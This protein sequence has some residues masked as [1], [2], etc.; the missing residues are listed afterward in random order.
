MVATRPVVAPSDPTAVGA[1]PALSLE[2]VIER[3]RLVV[4]AGLV[5]LTVLAWVYLFSMAADMAGMSDAM[6]AAAQ[7]PWTATQFVLMCLM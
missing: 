1:M 7:T 4:L 6:L 3:E 5:T 2:T